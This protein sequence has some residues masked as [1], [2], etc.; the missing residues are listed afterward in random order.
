MIFESP[1]F[2]TVTNQPKNTAHN[3][4]KLRDSTQDSQG[5][6]LTSY[7]KNLETWSP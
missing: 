3:L 1:A 4:Q 2:T 6:E 7:L 5:Q